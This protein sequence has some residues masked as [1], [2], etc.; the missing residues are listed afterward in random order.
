MAMVAP[1]PPPVSGRALRD[2]LLAFLASISF[3]V[4]LSCAGRGASSPNFLFVDDSTRGAGGLSADAAY[5]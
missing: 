1:A 2:P 5:Q 4:M 3:G